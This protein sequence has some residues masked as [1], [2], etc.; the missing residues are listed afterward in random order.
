VNDFSAGISASKAYSLSIDDVLTGQQSSP[1]G[2]TGEQAED[3]LSTYGSN[4][5]PQEKAPGIGKV[6]LYQFASPLIY[7]LIAAAFLS[8]VI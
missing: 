4:T 7:I 5:L 3:R 1:R 8:V 6:F 2:L